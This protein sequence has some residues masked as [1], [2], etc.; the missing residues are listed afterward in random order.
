MKQPNLATLMLRLRL[1]AIRLGPLACGALVLC[2]A[3]AAALAWLLPQ[4]ALQT[5]QRAVVDGLAALPAPVAPAPPAVVPRP[6]PPPVAPASRPVPP[7][8]PT[9]G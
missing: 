4:R 3:G 9:G 2:L 5:R 6:A 1:R 8:P 7:P